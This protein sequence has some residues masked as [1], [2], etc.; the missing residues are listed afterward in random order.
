MAALMEI[1]KTLVEND[2]DRRL[3][4]TERNDPD[5][6]AEARVVIGAEAA[7]ADVAGAETVRIARGD[8]VDVPHVFPAA[9]DR[10]DR[11]RV[12]ALDDAEAAAEEVDASGG[13]E[14]PATRKLARLAANF[15]GQLIVEIAELYILRFCRP[16]QLRAFSDGG[17]EKMFVEHI[18]PQLKRRHG[19]AQHAARFGRSR[20]SGYVLVREP[21]PKP[22]LRQMLGFEVLPHRQ[23]AREKHRGHLSGRFPDLLVKRLS[24][25]DD[26]HPQLRL[27]APQKNGRGR[28]GKGAAEDDYVEGVHGG[29]ASVH[30]R[31]AA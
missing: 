30:R 29:D 3:A 31:H 5:P 28:A 8:V 19:T 18:A 1:D 13:V 6:V 24:L 25:L 9:P 2:A 26:Q 11:M 23:P 27:L 17:G 12:V 22:F 4:I 21:V 7:R 10:G 15:D 14:E 20:V 16:Q